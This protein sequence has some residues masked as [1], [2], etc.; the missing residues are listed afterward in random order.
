MADESGYIQRFTFSERAV[1]ILLFASLIILS[2]TG[3]ALKYHESTI[4]QW[5]INVEGGVI[6]RGK[7]HRL[8]ALVLMATFIYHFLSILFSRRG[9]EFFRDMMF[10]RKDFSDFAGILKYNLGLRKEPLFDR[11][12]CVE[13]FQYWATGLA[14][15]FLGASGIMLWAET[16]FMMVLPKWVIDL[17][18]AVHSF[19][20]TLGFLVLIV[21]HLYNVHLNPR[22]F[23]MSRV[24]LTGKVSREDLRR[25][26]PLQYERLFGNE[27]N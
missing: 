1:H 19:E 8:A 6:F 20:A 4:G 17:N 27:K 5:L 16:L 22:V 2:I 3:L 12:S 7:V 9:N 10:T 15:V 25:D 24:W 18:R 23:P 11:F 26:H 21:W 14:I 13:K